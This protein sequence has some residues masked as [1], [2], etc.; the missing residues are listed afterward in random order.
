MVL[1]LVLFRPRVDLSAAE[2]SALLDALR[3]AAS[4]IP[5]I[6]RFRVGRRALHGREY[7]QLMREDLPYAAVLEFDDLDGLK[8]YLNHP[9]HQDLGNRFME[10]FAS[11]LIYDYEVEEADDIAGGRSSTRRP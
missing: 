6:R 2:Q 7:E 5:G 4:G 1:H 10:S 11:A 3:T 8:A 9:A